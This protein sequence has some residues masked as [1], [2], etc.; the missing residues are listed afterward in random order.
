MDV[1]SCLEVVQLPGHAALELQQHV[2]PQVPAQ[3]HVQSALWDLPDRN[4]VDL[5]ELVSHLH[6]EALGSSLG[7]LQVVDGDD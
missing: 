4:P 1:A 6:C 7:I 5:A 2:A 3:V